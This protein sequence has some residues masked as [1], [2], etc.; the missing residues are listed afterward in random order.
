MSSERLVIGICTFNRGERIRETLDAIAKM[1]R[2]GGLLTRLVVVNNASTDSTAA[3]IDAFIAS[4]PGVP[5]LR[6][7]EPE[8]GKIAAMRRLF[9]DTDEPLVGIIDDDTIP[10][11][12]WARAL[13][14][15]MHAQPRCGV[16]GGPVVNRWES[17]PTP[18]ATIYRR[19]LGDQ[20]RGE[21]RELL[22]GPE[23]FLMGASLVIRRG[24][25]EQSGWLERCELEARRGKA[26]ECGAEDAEICIRVRQSGWEIWYEPG[27]SMEHLIPAS[28]QTRAYLLRLREAIC[29]GE[30][31]LKWLAA[32]KPGREWAL[33][34][35]AKAR[36][37]Y[38]KTVLLN[39]RPTRR[40]I[41]VAERAGKQQ[42][43]ESL[44]AELE[45]R[46]DR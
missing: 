17:G 7:D 10:H 15:L 36:R 12:N 25:L 11:P 4:N 31:K 23:D 30:P 29:R 32:G 21:K 14:E 22:S 45:R 28:R 39:W 3:A 27:A 33:P 38:L 20:L 24:A 19:S 18:L 44:V 16:A 41:R 40:A 34:Q 46:A 35:L 13:I 6:I 9:K 1:D 8:P 2:A 42:G 26:L 5:T 37:K 43:W